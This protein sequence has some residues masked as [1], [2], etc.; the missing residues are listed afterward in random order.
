MKYDYNEPEKVM[1]VCTDNGNEVEGEILS[2]SH[3]SVRVN[4]HG[5][6]MNFVKIKPSVYVTNMSG[7]EFVIKL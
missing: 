2:T 5:I 3:N 7:K 6:V 4:V 1:V